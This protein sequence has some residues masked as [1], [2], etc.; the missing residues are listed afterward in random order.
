MATKDKAQAFIV[1]FGAEGYFLDQD[2]ERALSWKDR[3]IVRLSG[4]DV[5]EREL[6]GICETGSA[7]GRKRVVVLDDAEKVKAGKALN[8][9]VRDREAEDD[10]TVLVAIVRSEKCPAVWSEAAKKGRLIEHKK[11]KTFESNNEVVKWVEGEARRLGLVLDE[12]ISLLLYQLVGVNIYRLANEIRKLSVLLGKGGKVGTEQVKLVI[13]P[14]PTA[15]PYQVAEATL[16]KESRRAMNLLSTLYRTSGDEA[17]VPV[18]VSLIRQI[19]KVVLARSLIDRGASEED[20]ATALEMHPWRCKT[21]FLPMVQKHRM[22]DLVGH[23]RH[24]RALDE[25]VKGSARSKRT[26]V[27]LAVL[28]ISG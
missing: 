3:H 28:R 8:I 18:T 2:L 24:L 7:D 12:G 25:N 6:V 10:S 19:E 27:E 11:L 9:Y 20:I 5:D 1:S 16:A 13:S 4:E 17:H 14:S 22:A 21:Q 23:M 15:E 26:L